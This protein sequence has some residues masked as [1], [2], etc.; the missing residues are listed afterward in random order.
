VNAATLATHAQQVLPRSPDSA[1][2]YTQPSLPFSYSA[3]TAAAASVASLDTQHLLIPVTLRFSSGSHDAIALIDSGSS[4]CFMHPRVAAACG[5]PTLPKKSQVTAEAIDGRRLSPIL[6]ETPILDVVVGTTPFSVSFDILPC[7]HADVV[8]GMPWLSVAS[9]RVDWSRRTISLPDPAP[10]F[11]AATTTLCSA[12]VPVPAKTAEA[13]K[14]RKAVSPDSL[15]ELPDEFADFADVFGKKAAESLPPYRPFDCAIDLHDGASIPRS[16]RFRMSADEQKLASEYVDDFLAKGLIRPSRSP[17]GASM[18]FVPKKDGTKR[19]CIDYRELNKLTIRNAYPLP[20]IDDLLARLASAS[21]FTKIDLRSAYHLVRIRAGDEPKTA[22]YTPKGLY[23]YLVMPFGLVNAPSTFQHFVNDVFHDLL[24]VCVVVYL[25]DILVYSKSPDQ[26]QGHVCQVLQRLREHKLFAKLEKCEFAVPQVEFLGFIVSAKGIEMANSK[27]D[28]ILEWQ[29]PSNVKSVQRFLGFA[30]FYRRFIHSYSSIV[31]PLTQLTRKN[32]PFEWSAEAQIAFDHLKLAFTHGPILAH[33]DFAAPF[34]VETD[35]SDFALGAVLSQADTDG[36]LRPVAFHSR[37]LRDAELNY[38]VHDKELLAIIDAF[39]TWRHFLVGSPHEIVVYC[40][41]RNL[42]HWTKERNLN[43]RQA[44][45]ASFLSS[46]SPKIV[47]RAGRLQAKADALSR[48]D[49]LAPKEGGEGGAAGLADH[50][51]IPPHL[52][53]ADAAI[54]ATAT[55]K[56]PPTNDILAILKR[57][58]DSPLAGHFGINKTL[59]LIQRDYAWPTMKKD[60]SDYVKSCDVCCRSKTPRKKPS[61]LLHPLPVPTRPWASIS[62]DFITDLP[63]VNNMDSVLVIVDRFTKL[64]HFVPCSKSITAEGTV[65]LFV[66]RVLRYHG[67]PDTIVSDRGPQFVS[68]FWRRFHSLMGTST[69]LSSGYHP[70][71]NG[72]AERVNQVLE[73]Y[74]RCFTTYNQANWLI[75]LPYAE[76]AYNNADHESSK[77][78]PFF[79]TFGFHPRISFDQL[80]VSPSQVPAAEDRVQAIAEIHAQLQL[81]LKESQER[82]KRFADSQRRQSNPFTLGTKVWLRRLNMKTTRPCSKL[83]YKRIGPYVVKRQVNPVAF[84]LDL[85]AS[86][87]IHPVFHVSQ[88]DPV[89]ESS[90]PNRTNRPP[91]PIEIQGEQEYEVERVLDTRTYRRQKQYL[92]HWRGYPEAEATWEPA[93]NLRNSQDLVAEYVSRNPTTVAPKSRNRRRT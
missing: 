63:L 17:G 55:P 20:H 15:L 34:V 91:P 7:K 45:W 50:M 38:T 82:M 42:L 3:P 54:S 28:A 41:H 87:K 2:P 62:L 31:R 85:P 14:P 43:G 51:L 76:L 35:A 84:E 89:F 18:L 88:L 39:K 59:K 92:V 60:V 68:K 36:H 81:T 21:V 23:E 58:H 74:L 12:A 9:P 90:I 64:A 93:C 75:L 16:R 26:H 49:E 65:D 46:F 4:L 40:D 86:F 30:N 83:D 47:Y 72:Q 67:L 11:A 29:P 53:Q 22:F 77:F 73:Q 78:S 5:I 44:R 79:A 25:D 32:A 80:P 66:D 70:Q 69:D 33:A 13:N 27:V 48:R 61:G 71:T 6:H 19:L 52:V 1:L 37:A 56:P 57:Y 10:V 8:L 24:D